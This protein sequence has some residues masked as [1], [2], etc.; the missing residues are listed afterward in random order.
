MS[1]NPRLTTST[2]ALNV[3]SRD[4]RTRRPH[5]RRIRDLR[6]GRNP[7]A[8]AV[9]DA[10]GFRQSH[11]ALQLDPAVIQ[12]SDPRLTFVHG[13]DLTQSVA[14][15]V[16]RLREKVQDIERVMDVFWY[17]TCSGRPG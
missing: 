2:I 10:L 16:G 17:G 4:Q 12:L 8:L 5:L 13:V 9:P 15:V 1:D 11:S 7:R 3:I 6:V 14:R